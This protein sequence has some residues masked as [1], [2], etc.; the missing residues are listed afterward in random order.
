MV[1]NSPELFRCHPRKKLMEQVHDELKAE[2]VVIL[3]Y[4]Y[5]S[6]FNTMY[7]DLKAIQSATSDENFHDQLG[8]QIRKNGEWKS[9]LKNLIA[10]YRESPRSERLPKVLINHAAS[11]DHSIN[12]YHLAIREWD[13]AVWE[14]RDQPGRF[15]RD[16]HELPHHD[17]RQPQNNRQRRDQGNH[18]R[19]PEIIAH[20]RLRHHRNRD[21]YYNG[22][23]YQEHQAEH[24]VRHQQDGRERQNNPRASHSQHDTRDESNG[25]HRDQRGRQPVGLA[26]WGV[27][28][29]TT[30]GDLRGGVHRR[31]QSVQP[32]PRYD[33][34]E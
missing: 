16:R 12:R 34:K 4:D 30:F 22:H 29:W 17:G 18:C 14:G 25:R 15:K 31:A 27:R 19:H 23:Q 21:E 26:A 3:A 7:R 1:V 20:L 9:F 33:R 32:V 5:V 2:D 28:A 6:F 24:S 13:S 10:W 11:I 8:D